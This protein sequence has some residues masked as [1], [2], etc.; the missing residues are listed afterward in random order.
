MRM[1]D[2][3]CVCGRDNFIILT[4][5]NDGLEDETDYAE[6]WQCTNCSRLFLVR[7]MIVSMEELFTQMEVK[8]MLLSVNE[9]R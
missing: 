7:Y 1:K 4:S 6:I 9:V 8:T 3:K 5:K 2:L